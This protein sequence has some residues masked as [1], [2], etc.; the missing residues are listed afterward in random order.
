MDRK[1]ARLI[2]CLIDLGK[3]WDL[4]CLNGKPVKMPE[5]MGNSFFRLLAL[6]DRRMALMKVLVELKDVAEFLMGY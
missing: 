5:L 2:G 3:R 6:F 1:G 4:L